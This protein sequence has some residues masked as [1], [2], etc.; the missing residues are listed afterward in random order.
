GHLVP[1]PDLRGVAAREEPPR[2]DRPAT[3]PVRQGRPRSV[4]R[5]SGCLQF[6]PWERWEHPQRREL[7]WTQC[8]TDGIEWVGWRVEQ[9]GTH[10][11]EL[12]AGY[13][14]VHVRDRCRGDHPG[15]DRPR[16]RAGGLERLAERDRRAR[17]PGDHRAAAGA[18]LSGQAGQGKE[19]D[20]SRVRGRITAAAVVTAMLTLAIASATGAT[21]ASSF[22]KTET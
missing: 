9:G 7:R 2:G 14:H 8:R 12:R 21:A 1:Q 16:P 5:G 10:E 3:S 11:L 13:R 4:Q 20:M 19:R 17:A 15:A 18:R 22:T 6:E